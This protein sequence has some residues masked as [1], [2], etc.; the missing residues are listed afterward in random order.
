MDF[1]AQARDLVQNLNNRLS[2]SAYDIAWMARVRADDGGPRWPDLIDWLLE[3]QWPDGSWGGAIPYY[4]DRILCTLSALIA[5]RENRD[6]PLAEAAI[7]RGEQYIWKNLQF[8][9]HDLME[10]VGFELILPTLLAQAQKLG[11]DVPQHFCGY[12]RI[13]DS[14][15]RLL[16]LDMLYTPGVS[17]AFSIEFLG[18]EGDPARLRHLQGKNGAIANAPSTTAYLLTHAGNH[19]PAALEYLECVRALPRGAPDFYPLRTFEVTWV[20]EHLAFGDL[21]LSELVTPSLWQEL[22]AGITTQGIGFDPQFGISDGDTTSVTL[23]ILALGEQPV[24][25]AVL[26]FF[27]EPKTRIFRTFAFE[28]NMSVGTNIH[29]LEA[30]AVIPDYPDRRQ[31]WENIV[32]TLLDHQLYQTY[33][34]DKWHASPFYVTS[35]ALVA[36]TQMGEHQLVVHSQVVGWL[37]H[38]QRSD[39][40]WG[41]FDRG[42][43]EET[44]YALL[45]L[46][47]YHRYIAPINTDVLRRGAAYLYRAWETE[48]TYPELW[49]AKTLFTPDD[50]IRAAILAALALYAQMFG[51]LPE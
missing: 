50:I 43:A 41:Y 19:N 23:H 14:K 13:R 26:R 35:H 25:P 22:Q 5:L 46:L 18:D 37:L 36:L 21:P 45:A 33:W 11:L 12:G 31:V 7:R 29:A 3:H 24:D 28:R 44:A 38:T 49:I 34:I 8:L 20:L 4:H 39:G 27:E 17:V 1:V 10:L 9:R 51:R 47:H 30:L 16:P 15:L 40:S 2:P 6:G 48:T 42:T 32:A